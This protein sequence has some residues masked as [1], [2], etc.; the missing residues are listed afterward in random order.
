M[1]RESAHRVIDDS[2]VVHVIITGIANLVTIGIFLPAVRH[3][4]AVVLE[5]VL[6]IILH[7]AFNCYS[8]NY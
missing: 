8:L 3:Q 6:Q 5:T 7:Y 2:V 1:F 4:Q